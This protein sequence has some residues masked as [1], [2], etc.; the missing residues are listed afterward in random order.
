MW[1]WGYTLYPSRAQSN[2][3]AI[4]P[5]RITGK[6]HSSKSASLGT[7][8][9][10]AMSPGWWLYMAP[11]CS[12]LALGRRLADCVA[13]EAICGRKE[14]NQLAQSFSS[15]SAEFIKDLVVETVSNIHLMEFN[16]TTSA[17][18]RQSLAMM[19]IQLS[20]TKRA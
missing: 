17:Y 9:G 2:W 10:M 1:S 16:L 7:S 4:D 18:Q 8:K 6:R 15:R 3:R 12:Q 11:N 14:S 20:Y 19:P 13:T 5:R